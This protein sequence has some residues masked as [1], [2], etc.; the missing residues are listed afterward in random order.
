MFS[1]FYKKT[2]L[3]KY[4]HVNAKTV[5]FFFSNRDYVIMI[6]ICWTSPK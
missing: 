5:L 1:C 2:S 4:I 6:S 3:K